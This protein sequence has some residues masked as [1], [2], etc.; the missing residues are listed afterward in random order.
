MSSEPDEEQREF[1]TRIWQA[2]E[3]I[4]AP[5]DAAE[6]IRHRDARIRAECG[7]FLAL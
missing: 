6:L 5:D 3:N 7:A 4:A 2:W 1:A